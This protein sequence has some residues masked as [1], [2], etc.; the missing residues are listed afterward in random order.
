MA[1]I[2]SP[3]SF[4]SALHAKFSKLD[5]DQKKRLSLRVAANMGVSTG[6]INRWLEGR[7]SPHRDMFESVLA[8]VDVAK[9]QLGL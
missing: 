5:A 7:S 4:Q 1:V 9:Q 3:V 8:G 2:S 6:S